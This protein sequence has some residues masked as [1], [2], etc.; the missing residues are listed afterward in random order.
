M[1][2]YADSFCLT[3]VKAFL[4]MHCKNT[5]LIAWVLVRTAKQGRTKFTVYSNFIDLYEV[6]PSGK[7]SPGEETNFAKCS[8]HSLLI[9]SF[10]HFSSLSKRMP[11]LLFVNIWH[12]GVSSAKTWLCVSFSPWWPWSHLRSILLTDW[13]CWSESLGVTDDIVGTDGE[14]LSGEENRYVAF[15][16]LWSWFF[17][18]LLR[19]NKQEL[20]FS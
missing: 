15:L 10:V 17:K 1:L 18:V 13:S 7:L 11:F 9:S 3:S 5:W 6:W 14:S 8:S 2:F 20:W 4:K 12:P 16:V 19:W